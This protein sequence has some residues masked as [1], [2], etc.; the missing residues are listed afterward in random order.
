MLYG[1]TIESIKYLIRQLEYINC[2]VIILSCQKIYLLAQNAIA[3]RLQSFLFMTHIYC[4][5]ILNKK[6]S[7]GIAVKGYCLKTECR[8]AYIINLIIWV[9]SN[10]C[11]YITILLYIVCMCECLCVCVCVKCTSCLGFQIFGRRKRGITKMQ[12]T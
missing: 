11:E 5:S 7:T 12:K 3:L 10:V 6:V 8:Y 4:P 2:Y 1:I 9:R